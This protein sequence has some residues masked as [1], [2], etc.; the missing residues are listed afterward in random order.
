MQN[1]NVRFQQRTGKLTSPFPGLTTPILG[2]QIS[3]KGSQPPLWDILRIW[4]RVNESLFLQSP[5]QD[6]IVLAAQG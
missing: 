5:A 4:I 1:E 3:P 6:T 2:G